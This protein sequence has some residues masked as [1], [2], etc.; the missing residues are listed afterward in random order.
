MYIKKIEKIIVYWIL[1]IYMQS[2]I[3]IV[4]LLLL[5]CFA[6]PNRKTGIFGVG[7]D[8]YDDNTH[9]VYPYDDLTDDVPAYTRS[10]KR[11]R[12]KSKPKLLKSG[13]KRLRHD[14]KYH[15]R[16]TQRDTQI[17][18]TWVHINTR[19]SLRDEEEVLETTRDELQI[20]MQINEID[21]AF[22]KKQHLGPDSH[23]FIT[24][25]VALLEQ[26]DDNPAYEIHYQKLLKILGEVD[27]EIYHAELDKAE[28][29]DLHQRS[30]A[31]KYR[32]VVQKLT[33]LQ[34]QKEQINALT[35][36]QINALT[37]ERDEI[38]KVFDPSLTCNSCRLT[39]VKCPFELENDCQINEYDRYVS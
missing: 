3:M 8:E 6:L 15:T 33:K 7:K 30:F 23:V 18:P 36:E 17:V 14:F 13:Q 19:G 26:C 9:S 16:A 12:S 37:K 4:N 22:A 2:T 32:S 21:D 28:L 39:L 31:E 25:I 10:S 11:D 29:E 5:T 27:Q 1:K 34:S 24:S 38:L 35:K 20:L